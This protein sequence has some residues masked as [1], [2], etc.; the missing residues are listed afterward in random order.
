[1]NE[2]VSDEI[3]VDHGKVPADTLETVE[4]F[5]EPDELVPAAAEAQGTVTEAAVAM[6][7][8]EAR[9]VPATEVSV[10]RA[11]AGVFAA[12]GA[13]FA[14]TVPGESFLPLLGDLPAAGVRVVSARH[15]GGASFMA[16]AAAQLTG[17]PQLVLATRTVGAANAAI[18][19][20][21]ARADSVPLVAL[22]GQVRRA[23]R[24]REAFQESELATG[25]GSLA[26]WSAE[27]G[28]PSAIART[29]G[30]GLR[31]LTTGRP[32]PILLA[33]PEDVLD[34]HLGAPIAPPA[35]GG[36][37]PAADRAAVRRILK[38][39]AAS[40]RGVILA[41]TG[42][43]RAR[44]SRRLVTLSEALAIP[45]ITSWRHGDAFPN[46]HP[47]YLGMSGYW[48]PTTVRERLLEAD[49]LLV[50]GSR[51]SEVTTFGYQVPAPMTRWAH[52]DLEPRVAHAGLAAPT[53]AVAADV[54]RFLDAAWA[55]LRGVVLDAETRGGR[56]AATEADRAAYLAASSVEGGTWAGPGV[57]PGRVVATLQ[58][59]LPPNAILT[60]DAGN[61]AGWIARG[62]R[63]R[64]PGTFLGPTSGAMG[65]GLPAAIAASLVHPDRVSVAVCGDGG[66]AMTMS[67]LETAVR[68]GARPIV[69]VFDNQ[70]YG[71]IAMHQA[72]GSRSG[73]TSTLG[74]ID[75][76]AVATAC[77]ALGIRVDD[78]AAFEPALRAALASSRPTV[79]HLPLD[80]RWVSVDDTP[81]EA[82]DA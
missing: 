73:A 3:P 21:T 80:P 26:K 11:I 53:L 77:G 20:H 52:V 46:D 65:Y 27:L 81:G 15:E 42:V 6:P 7:A 55:D 78:D 82:P 72:R 28:D 25:I 29:V 10:S 35:T 47:N 24:G 4:A 23:N 48:A 1:L 17:R 44:A 19:L 69:L 32:G 40:R 49:V 30:E 2:A 74:P 50:L 75:F 45:V 5:A 39:L 36:Q 58:A 63:F 34:E 60:T 64:R 12:A 33:V 41:G 16:E 38:W 67:E 59:V 57:H 79:I 31:H 70:Q 8:V 71:T 54:S 68:E 9:S 66:L 22:V 37:G 43:L 51:L 61:F 62:Y 76:A 13:R 14:F 18:G 56:A